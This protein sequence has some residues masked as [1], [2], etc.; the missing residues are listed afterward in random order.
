M[1]T[2][3]TTKQNTVIDQF[4]PDVIKCVCFNAKDAD[5]VCKYFNRQHEDKRTTGN[6]KAELRVIKAKLER[7]TAILREHDL[8]PKRGRK[9]GVKSATPKAPKPR[10]TRICPGYGG[11]APHEFTPTGGRQILCPACKIRRDADKRSKLVK[12]YGLKTEMRYRQLMPAEVLAIT[13]PEERNKAFNQLSH[14]Q[15]IEFQKL[16]TAKERE[17]W[18][19][20]RNKAFALNDPIM[21]VEGL[22]PHNLATEPYQ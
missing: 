17:E 20:R 1:D 18:R 14:A 2:Y 3:I 16:K 5:A 9:A 4:H 15:Q 7:Y 19:K 12:N 10:K 13:D 8:L 11:V 21:G 6:T 22:D